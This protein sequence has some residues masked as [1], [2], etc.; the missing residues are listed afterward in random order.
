MPFDIYPDIVDANGW[1]SLHVATNVKLCSP[2]TELEVTVLDEAIAEVMEVLHQKRE[3][4]SGA[5]ETG[6]EKKMR[7]I[8]NG[9]CIFAIACFPIMGFAG[10]AVIQSR[11]PSRELAV[12]VQN[13]GLLEILAA[14]SWMIVD[15]VPA[16]VS[17]IRFDT[18]AYRRRKRE[19]EHDFGHLGALAVFDLKVLQLT[20]KWLALKIERMKMRIGNYLGGSDK[21]A[22]FALVSAGWTVWKNFPQSNLSWQAQAY[23]VG[24]AMLVGLAVGGMLVNRAIRQLSYQRD[25]LALA[26]LQ[27][28]N[29][30]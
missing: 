4:P 17:V 26:M 18:Y 28:Q 14:V 10:W 15:I 22:V 20:D 21:V 30:Q 16:A 13:I 3:V 9:L 2:R 1:E 7:E 25:L 8:S 12:L 5:L 11:N 29:A 19:V 6:F 23:L 24:L 27:V